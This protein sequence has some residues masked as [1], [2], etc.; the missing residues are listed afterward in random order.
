MKLLSRAMAIT[1]KDEPSFSLNTARK[2]SERIGTNTCD[3][4]EDTSVAYGVSNVPCVKLILGIGPILF[5]P[6]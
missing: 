6:R 3:M 5:A 1:S 4:N 2:K